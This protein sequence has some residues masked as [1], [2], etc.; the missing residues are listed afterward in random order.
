[1]LKLAFPAFV[2]V[3]QY[4]ADEAN[5]IDDIV[6]RSGLNSSEVLATLFNLGMKGIIRHVPGKQFS[7]VLLQKHIGVCIAGQQAGIQ[8]SKRIH[9][10]HRRINT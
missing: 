1:V 4:K 6:E 7:K 3:I 8:Y 5:Y 9:K 10:G 2:T